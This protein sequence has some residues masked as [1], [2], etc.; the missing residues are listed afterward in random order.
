MI[1]WE[2]HRMKIRERPCA[3]CGGQVN[4]IPVKDDPDKVI[5][6]CTMCPEY[7]IRDSLNGSKT[8]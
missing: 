5:E 3:Y 7:W 6:S 8:K 2:K 1:F 4:I